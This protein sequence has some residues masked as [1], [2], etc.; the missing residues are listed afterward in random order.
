MNCFLYI[1]IEKITHS[2]FQNAILK[3]IKK[4]VC[5]FPPITNP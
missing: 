1:I 3:D 5:W 2:T 4:E